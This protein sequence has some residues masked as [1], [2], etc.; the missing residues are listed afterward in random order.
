MTP[1]TVGPKADEHCRKH[2]C[3]ARLAKLKA[4]LAKVTE[5]EVARDTNAAVNSANAACMG[6]KHRHDAQAAT[7]RTAVVQ[8]TCSDATAKRVTEQV[9]RLTEEVAALLAQV[10][11]LKSDLS[12]DIGKRVARAK[13]EKKMAVS[14]HEKLANAA[15]QVAA[16]AARELVVR[17]AAAEEVEA[18]RE[19]AAAAAAA[20]EDA[21]R[22]AAALQEDLEIMGG[23]AEA[24]DVQIADAR[25]EAEA[26]REEVVQEHAAR[27]EAEEKVLDGDY[28]NFL[29]ERRLGRAQ[30]KAD[31]LGAWRPPAGVDDDSYAQLSREAQ[32][33]RRSRDRIYL[34]GLFASRDFDLEALASALDEQW[35][36]DSGPSQLERLVLTTRRGYA[37]HCRL[38]RSLMAR[39][40]SEQFGLE[41]GLA[42][43]FE[44]GLTLD[45]ILRIT[46]S[47]SKHY[48][49]Q[50]DRYEAV[51]LLGDRDGS[52]C[53]VAVPRLAPPRSQLEPAI[54]FVKSLLHIETAESGKLAYR[55]FDECMRE[56]VLEDTG[57][58]SGSRSHHARTRRRPPHPTPTQPTTT[59][60]VRV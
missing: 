10:A 29:L 5:L 38:V 24:L 6:W 19:A 4:A 56:L 48:N 31:E 25:E 13:A 18:A 54:N 46:Q 55:D 59:P 44:H 26:A 51:T 21:Q 57:T 3:V 14:V 35:E 42:L 22:R 53:K 32:R 47:A 50:R 23:F 36:D 45:R 20:Q 43:Y 11:V 40:E 1:R 60:P 8:R 52:G 49:R 7:A 41:F 12:S 15:S 39:I 2:R 37:L 16:A 30:V 58:G 28:A 17:K 9:T 34:R 33:Q 27:K